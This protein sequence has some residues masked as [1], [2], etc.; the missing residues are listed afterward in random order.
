MRLLFVHSIGTV[1]G[2]SVGEKNKRCEIGAADDDSIVGDE[3][4]VSLGRK[5]DTGSSSKFSN[6]STYG[7]GKEEGPGSYSDVKGWR[8]RKSIPVH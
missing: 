8:E 3:R 1:R 5:R 4:Q 6:Q 2:V 7:L